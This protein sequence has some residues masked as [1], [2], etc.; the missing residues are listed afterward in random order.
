L[1]PFL[2]NNVRVNEPE[3]L[4]SDE[5]FV[6]EVKPDRCGSLTQSSILIQNR[7]RL[8]SKSNHEPPPTVE[9]A[10]A[11]PPAPAVLSK[12]KATVDLS[13]DEPP[14]DTPAV[15]PDDSQSSS[16]TT[17]P[18]DS[19]SSSADFL[20]QSPTKVLQTLS[21]KP[22][23]APN[24]VEVR[25]PSSS[26]CSP[27]SLPRTQIKGS[28]NLFFGEP[29]A[30]KPP[31]A[32]VQP[33]KKIQRV[34]VD[35]SEEEEEEAE[36]DSPRKV[37]KAKSTS[38]ASQGKRV[39]TALP[40][41]TFPT[42]ISIESVP[43]QGRE[44]CLE[45]YRIAFTGVMGDFMSRSDLEALVLQYGGKVAQS[46]SGKTTFLVVSPTLEDGRDSSTSTKYRTAVD[47]KVSQSVHS[48]HLSSPI[49][50]CSSGQDRHRE[51]LLG[52]DPSFYR[53]PIEAHRVDSEPLDLCPGRL[54]GVQ[55][56]QGPRA[57]RRTHSFVLLF[58]LHLL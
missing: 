26:S 42:D 16:I 3:L 30:P 37:S 1:S 29:D 38:K 5:D 8:K 11:P 7:K 28:V 56:R 41:V 22:K 13:A 46:I 35:E 58:V 54:C 40:P 6:E 50:F 36:E 12:R 4:D 32:P 15:L 23:T 53:R 48:S 43:P 17:L 44:G 49:L 39:S 9:P 20:T 19:Q 31:P 18:N 52:F 27:F 45:G 34:A 57:A 14:P 55:T 2:P 33:P 51:R 21:R 47:K 25:S 10:P 24:R